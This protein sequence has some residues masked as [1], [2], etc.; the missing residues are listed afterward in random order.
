MP[1]L[2]STFGGGDCRESGCF[3]Q[4]LVDSCL[5]TRNGDVSTCLGTCCGPGHDSAREWEKVRGR[6]SGGGSPGTSAKVTEGGEQGSRGAP[7]F[8]RAG[9]TGKGFQASDAEPGCDGQ[10]DLVSMPGRVREASRARP[11]SSCAAL[12]TPRSAGQTLI[13]GEVGGDS[14]TS[15]AA[16][17]LCVGLAETHPERFVHGE[18]ELG[19]SPSVCAGAGGGLPKGS[20]L[21]SASTP[22]PGSPAGGIKLQ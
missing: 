17:A 9:S 13:R 1:S 20:Q 10:E 22:V 6:S 11:P 14:L 19:H 3:S 7:K 5:L 16:S 21:A 8:G 4:G 15:P 18:A 2:F 12:S